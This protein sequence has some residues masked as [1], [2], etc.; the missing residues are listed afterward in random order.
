MHVCLHIQNHYVTL[1]SLV[2]TKRTRRVRINDGRRAKITL[3]LAYNEFGYNEQL[4]TTT[5]SY[6]IF[7]LVVS[8]E[9]ATS[10]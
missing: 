1:I 2:P 10:V 7:L 6:C 9:P 8:G 5:S 3:I 4:F